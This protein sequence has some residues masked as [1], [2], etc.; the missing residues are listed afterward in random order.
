MWRTA[1]VSWKKAN[2]PAP[3]E[4]LEGSAK[5]KAAAAKKEAAPGETTIPK[6]V[7]PKKKAGSPCF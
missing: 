7:R 3:K 2:K 1:K 5:A 6:G 4:K